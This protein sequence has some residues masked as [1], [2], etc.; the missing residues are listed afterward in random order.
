MNTL[1]T[2]L[3][4]RERHID[5]SHERDV[6]QRKCKIEASLQSHVSSA[7]VNAEVSLTLPRQPAQERDDHALDPKAV[8]CFVVRSSIAAYAP[9]VVPPPL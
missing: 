1:N 4:V 5:V 3:D 7:Q 9:Q 8:P 6:A 2:A